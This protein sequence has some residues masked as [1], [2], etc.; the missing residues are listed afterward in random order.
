ITRP[1]VVSPAGT[2][3]SVAMIATFAALIAVLALTPAI[4]FGPLVVP[5]T[6]QTLG[7]MLAGAVLGPRNGGLAVGLYLLVG[8]AGVPIFAQ[9]TGGLA[10]LAAPSAGYLLSF[11]LAAVLIG[12]LA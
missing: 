6:L 8:L 10:V 1:P 11:P 5:I 12:F 4:T 2:G 3:S 7:V 9:F